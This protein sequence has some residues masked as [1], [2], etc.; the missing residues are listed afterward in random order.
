MQPNYTFVL[1]LSNPNIQ[2]QHLGG[3]SLEKKSDLAMA[4]AIGSTSNSNTVTLV[5][6]GQ[7]IG[8]GVGQK[9]RVGCCELAV[10]GA[11]DAGHNVQGATAYSDSF[12][13][14]PDGPEILAKAGVSV[15]LASSGSVNDVAT[16]AV[17][18]QYGITLIMIPDTIGRGFY[19]H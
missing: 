19:G 17:C 5:K 7:L 9:D 11:R 6:R 3:V 4:W 10:R 2:I 14:F 12:F 16:K 15:I 13:P 18:E 1:D 8:N